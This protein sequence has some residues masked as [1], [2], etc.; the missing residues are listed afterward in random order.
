MTKLSPKQ[1]EMARKNE[2]TVLRR[3][4]A[5]TQKGLSDMLGCSESKISRM[6]DGDLEELCTALAALDLQIVAANAC[7]VTPAERKFMA[8]QMIK[9]YQAILDEETHD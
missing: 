3:L 6:K 2:R 4:A 9:H 1:F 7:L 8:E 5:V